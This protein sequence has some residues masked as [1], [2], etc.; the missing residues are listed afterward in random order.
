MAGDLPLLLNPFSLISLG[1]VQQVREAGAEEGE[2]EQAVPLR[3][4]E[5][6]AVVEREA[7][8]GHLAHGDVIDNLRRLIVP[9]SLIIL[10]QLGALAPL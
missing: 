2:R 5:I 9:N 8:A 7:E 4:P 10:R 1:G 3:E 6:A